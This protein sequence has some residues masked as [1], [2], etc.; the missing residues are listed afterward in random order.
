M[1]GDQPRLHHLSTKQSAT[2]QCKICRATIQR[3]E[4]DREDLPAEL[5]PLKTVCPKRAIMMG[6]DHNT[7]KELRKVFGALLKE[8]LPGYQIEGICHITFKQ[9]KVAVRPVVVNTLSNFINYF[10]SSPWAS[11]TMQAK[12][13]ER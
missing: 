7:K 1:L 12:K 4:E 3:R 8:G 6:G 5:L 9:S 13:A 10:L 11:N 2:G